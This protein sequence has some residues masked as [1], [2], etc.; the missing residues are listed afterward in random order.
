MTSVLVLFLG[1]ARAALLVLGGFALTARVRR[2]KWPALYLIAGV[3][4][5]PDSAD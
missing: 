5:P 4:S 1:P 3:K 2:L